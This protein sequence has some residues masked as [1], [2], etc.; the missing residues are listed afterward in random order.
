M[1]MVTRYQ[2]GGIGGVRC[3]EIG[4]EDLLVKCLLLGAKV[5]A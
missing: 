3:S 4:A 2:M 5:C 1:D